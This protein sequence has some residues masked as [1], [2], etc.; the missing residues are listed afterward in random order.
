MKAI[1]D[2]PFIKT[3]RVGFNNPITAVMNGNDVDKYIKL[4]SPLGD[5]FV[6]KNLKVLP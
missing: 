2:Y 4:V 5:K 1:F 3:V 6:M